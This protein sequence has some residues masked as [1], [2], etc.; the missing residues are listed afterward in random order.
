MGFGGGPEEQKRMDVN[1]LDGWEK[2][3]TGTVV[4]AEGCDLPSSL[5]KPQKFE[6]Q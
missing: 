1:I 4:L 3:F 5:L 6:P 2:G